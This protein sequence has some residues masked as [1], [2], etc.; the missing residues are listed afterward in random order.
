MGKSL[1]GVCQEWKD[2]KEHEFQTMIRN[3]DRYSSGWVNWRIFASYIILLDS[4]I[5]NDA[6][7]DKYARE[8]KI[9]DSEGFLSKSDFI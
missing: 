4:T 8:L 7:G 5:I 2:Y 9:R 3:L 1:G 6:S